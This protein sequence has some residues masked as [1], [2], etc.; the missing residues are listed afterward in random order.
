VLV[1]L[2]AI[3]FWDALFLSPGQIL[4]GNDLGNM[5]YHWHTFARSSIREGRLPLWNPFL[6][7]GQPFAANPQPAIFYPATWLSL[8]MPVAASLAVNVVLH[9]WLAGAG[10]F[11][12]LR[13][14]RAS[15][16][17]AL[18]GALVFA[19]SGYLFV[20][21]QAGHLGVIAT[22]AWLPVILWLYS[23]AVARRSFVLAAVGGLPVGFSLLAGHT[24]SF[25]YVLL[26]A[27]AY[28]LFFAVSLWREHRRA[29]DA[30]LP[31]GLLSAAVLAG[32]AVSAVQLL[33]LARFALQSTRQAGLGYEFA[34]RFSWPP[35]YLLT[36]LVPNFF[37]EPVV[38]GYWGDGIYDEVIFYAGVLP[39]MLAL[40]GVRLRHRLR[41]FLPAVGLCAL[42]LAFGQYGALH[43][44]FYR[45]VP[46]FSLT[47]APARAGFL[48]V[49]VVAALSGLAL[50]ALEF[51]TEEVRRTLLRPLSVPAVISVAG[52]A[53]VLAAA[54]FGAFALG[55]ETNPA[56][57]RLWHA[58]NRTAMFL[59]LFILSAGLLA[60]WRRA[61]VPRA[62]PTVLALGLVLVDLWAFGGEI[63]R[64]VDAPE[65]AYWRIV[66]EAVPDPDDWRILPWG[67]NDFDQNGG[68]PYGLRSVFGYDPLVL[69][70]YE[71]FISSRPDPQAATYDLLSA[72]YLVTPGPQDFGE[73]ASAP[74]L[75]LEQAGVW[76]YERTSALP[77]AWIA[78][79]VEV[80][81]DEHMLARIHEPT[82]DPATTAL[83]DHQIECDMSAEG[84]GAQVL[85]DRGNR[86]QVRVTGGGGLL[87][88]SEVDYAGWHATIDGSSTPIVRADYLLRAICVPPGE[89]TVDLTYG[90]PLVKVGLAVSTCA[91]LVI[92]ALAL[93]ARRRGSPR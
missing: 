11:A 60:V 18:F 64:V 79:E 92:V 46:L 50:S 7:S 54:G 23:V 21:V 24:A 29:R 13:S 4:A 82:F 53:A 81:S 12:W 19:F 14:E 68:M 89:H 71:A 10:M 35:G 73:D 57:G 44:L 91:L 84:G 32:L 47:R 55:R 40:L 41:Y 43:P 76:V 6:F 59:L 8:V 36:L 90:A 25:V 88:L 17:S 31:I 62:W 69:E 93:A 39:L 66:N 45:Y 78:Q 42:L 2:C 65:N 38:T 87:V 86:L 72:R 3:L 49:F 16:G 63:V 70:R 74:R 80:V 9:V 77:R 34:S 15:Q 20:R 1:L 52:V 27:L 37:G 5:F 51:E 22:C 33:P 75:L 61:R 83:L 58:A 67:L 30:L 26:G 56:A 85:F 28:A 48:F